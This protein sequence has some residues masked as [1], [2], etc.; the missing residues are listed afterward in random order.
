MQRLIA[1]VC[2]ATASRGRTV[3]CEA[4]A[5][6]TV[7]R[8]TTVYAHVLLDSSVQIVNGR[9]HVPTTAGGTAFANQGPSA[10]VARASTASTA[11]IDSS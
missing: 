5:G 3:P 6:A 9:R 11:V 10:I 7:G 8:A 1:S 2:V 4:A